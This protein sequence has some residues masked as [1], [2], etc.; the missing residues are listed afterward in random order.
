MN[1][2]LKQLEAFV[3]VVEC[4][5]FTAAAE[6][7]GMAKSSVS[8]AIRTLETRLGVRLLNRTTRALHPTEAG[9]AFHAR[10]RKLLDDAA[11]AA[12]EAQALQAAPAGV[13]RCAV[14]EAFARLYLVPALAGFL[15][16]HPALQLEM[17]EG[18]APVDLVAE[19]LDLAIRVT[20]APAPGLVVR[21]LGTSRVIVVAAPSYLAEH[22]TPDLPPDVA[23]HRCIGFSPLAWRDSWRLGDQVVAVRPVLLS[24]G[25]EA[26]RAAAL[27]GIGLVAVPD[28]LVA[29]ALVAGSLRQVLAEHPGPESGIFAVYPSNRLLAPKVRAFVDHIARELRR[30]GVA[31]A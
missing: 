30:R 29:D 4:G 17:V 1:Y 9:R 16:S 12:G 7:L 13:L 25:T 14:P 18:V 2:N 22:G 19:G 26:M 15:A 24:N 31:A 5:S 3:A 6:Q 27:A 11:A 8:E 21:R 23:R 10:C 28:W 20:A